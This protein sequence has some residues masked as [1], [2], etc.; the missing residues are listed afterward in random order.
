MTILVFGKTGQVAQE[1][2]KLPETLC[3]GRD[4]ADLSDPAGC[5][6]AIR[7][8]KPAA[9]INAAAYTAVDAAETDEAQATLVNGTAPGAMA[10]ACAAL[11]IPLVQISTDYVFAG[12]GEMPW[13]PD[14]A[15][16]PLGAYGR[17]KLAGEMAVRDA[18]G[19]H[20]ILR[21]SWVVSAHGAN[22]IKTML[23]LGAERDSLN[24]VAD[25][26]GGPTAAA[27]IAAACHRIALQLTDA[28]DKTGTYHFSGAPDCSW[29]DFARAIF[30]E[31][32]LNCTVHDIPSSGYPTPAKRPLNSRMDCGT[33]HK[34]FGIERPQWQAS[35]TQIL[36]DL[37]ASK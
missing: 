29:A 19:A 5:G 9:V 23:R 17:S 36:K 27:D 25:Q 34:T 2:A 4:T 28:P 14:D 26:I 21:T 37:G 7:L 6:D 31:A 13:Q 1:L 16:A 20:A 15:T 24:V 10:Q 35:L 22:F 30:D 18:G 33:T 12:H 11:G 8:H 3:L 32:G